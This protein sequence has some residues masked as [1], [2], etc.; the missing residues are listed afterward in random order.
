[1]TA[2]MTQVSVPATRIGIPCRQ[3]TSPL[4]SRFAVLTRV[5]AWDSRVR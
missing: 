3:E 2:A 1:M 4:D 5:C